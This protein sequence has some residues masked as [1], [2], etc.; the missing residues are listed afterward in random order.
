MASLSKDNGGWRI[1][2]VC[3]ATR[4]RRTIR[5]GKCAKKNAETARNMIER[6][7][8][9]KQ[10]GSALD[11]Q[12]IE[13]LKGID[14]KLRERLAKV[15]LVSPSEDT[16]IGEFLRSYI[17]GHKVKQSTIEHLERVEKDLVEFFGSD[18]RIDAVTEADAEDFARW[19]RHDRGLGDNT[20]RRRIGRAK[21]FFNRAVGR[22]MVAQNP[23]KGQQSV[24]HANEERFYFVSKADTAKILGAC[25][26]AQWRLIVT[27]SR[28]GGIRVPSE[29]VPLRWSDVDWEGGRLT[30]TS[31]KTEHHQGKAYRVIPLF[32]ELREA[33][34]DCFESAPDGAEYVIEGRYRSATKNLRTGFLRIVRRAGL[35]PWEKPFQNMRSSR[36]TELAE[37]WPLHV[38]VKWCGNSQPVAAKHY[39]QVTDEHFEKAVQKPA[40]KPAQSPHFSAHQG[41]PKKPQNPV[42]SEKDEVCG[43]VNKRQAPRQGLEPWT[44]RL[45]AAC[46]TN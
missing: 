35:E 6:L 22:R 4:K 1:L 44:K 27:L 25:P 19:L 8:E 31:P 39:L 9:A 41:S 15:G 2:F 10:H 28:Y 43:T 21:Q 16:A 37:D 34:Q 26:N 24:V 29:L 32:P 30:V 20:A 14:G 5:T 33:L 13:W 45:T 23:F 38:V 36:E 11:G 12:T 7:I 42:F 40:Q 18:K 46:S 3:P 17:V